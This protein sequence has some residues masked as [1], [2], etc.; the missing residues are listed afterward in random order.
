MSWSTFAVAAQLGLDQ[1]REHADLRGGAG[2]GEAVGLRRELRQLGVLGR[3]RAVHGQKI[4][5]VCRK[6]GA[7]RLE[8]GLDPLEL[9]ERGVLR[10]GQRAERVRGL[11]RAQHR[12]G[13]DEHL[14]WGVL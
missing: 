11:D 3:E 1:V 13:R 6:V 10:I 2:G 9:H 5:L 7:L 8:I 14:E 12:A 4:G